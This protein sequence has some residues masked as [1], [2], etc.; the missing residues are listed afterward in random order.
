MEDQPNIADEGE[1]SLK[2]NLFSSH[3]QNLTS[4]LMP[5][6]QIRMIQYLLGCGSLHL[7][8]LRLRFRSLKT[9]DWEIN[10]VT[11]TNKIVFEYRAL[12]EKLKNLTSRYRRI[13]KFLLFILQSEQIGQVLEPNSH[14]NKW[15]G[16]NV[17][18]LSNAVNVNF[19][20]D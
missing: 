2:V 1:R 19:L 17:P 3:Y 4:T 14:F 6:F 5:I 15:G 7:E 8:P 12:W 18:F 9:R 20:N 11:F 16:Q 10:T 13:H